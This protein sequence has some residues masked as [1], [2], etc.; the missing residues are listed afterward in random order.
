MRIYKRKL[1]RVLSFIPGFGGLLSF[2]ILYLSRK[3]KLESRKGLYLNIFGILFLDMIIIMILFMFLAIFLNQNPNL[4]GLFIGV[5][6]I[7]L[8]IIN[9]SFYLFYKNNVIDEI[10]EINK[11]ERE[12]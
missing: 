2:S 3:D 10:D 1:Y 5:I 9:F 6:C 11:N 4:Y 12:D 7:S 8:Y